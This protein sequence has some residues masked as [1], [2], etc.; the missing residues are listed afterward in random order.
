M[1]KLYFD[2]SHYDKA[3]RSQLFPLLK[4]FKKAKDYTDKERIETYGVSKQDFEFESAIKNADI[5][6]LTMS[7]NYY[8]EQNKVYLAKLIIGEALLLD[9]VVWS[10]SLGDLSYKLPFYNHVKVFRSSGLKSKLS[11]TNKGM[12]VFIADPL[13]VYFK[14]NT[15]YPPEYSVMPKV[16]F[17]GQASGEFLQTIKAFIKA[18]A[19]RLI[20]VFKPS[21]FEFDTI[22]IAPFVRN[23]LLKRIQKHK[24]IG[25]NFIFREKYRAGA[26]T[27]DLREKTTLEYYNNINQSQYVLCVRGA[28]NFSVRFY[29][30]LAMGRIPVFVNTDCL[31]PLSE[32][33]DWKKHVVW[34]EANEQKYIGKKIVDFH[35]GL[36]EK[37]F[38]DICFGNRKLWQEKLCIGGFFKQLSIELLN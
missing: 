15:L 19:K 8:I 25:T 29:D 17:C 14:T 24:H 12:P 27:N 37:E 36:T 4:P 22:F 20:N 13:N 35:N 31:L 21:L 32:F 23:T 2:D 5:I 11:N 26:N 34:I 38:N 9:K 6:I 1:L 3:F 30:T 16:G 10:V 33:I 7:W 28:G 18:V